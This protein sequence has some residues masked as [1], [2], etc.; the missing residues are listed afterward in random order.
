MAQHDGN[1]EDQPQRRRHRFR[2]ELEVGVVVTGKQAVEE[3]DSDGNVVRRIDGKGSKGMHRVAWNLRYASKTIH[4]NR[5]LAEMSTAYQYS[6]TAQ[7][8]QCILLI[9]YY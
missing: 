9:I 2:H 3:Q 1:E 8:A 4:G 6:R 5:V 7:T